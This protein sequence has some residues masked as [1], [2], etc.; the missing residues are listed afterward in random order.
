MTVC[1]RESQRVRANLVRA[2]QLVFSRHLGRR[3]GGIG[4]EKYCLP[5]APCAW[6]VV[7]QGLQGSSPY[8]PISPRQS[9]A[10]TLC[11]LIH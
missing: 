10:L 1:P 4:L 11:D 8:M 9:K 3:H 2:Y 5:L 6:T 7:A